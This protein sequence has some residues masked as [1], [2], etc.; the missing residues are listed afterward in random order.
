MP[1]TITDTHAGWTCHTG[2][3]LIAD[4]MTPGPG[5]LGTLHGV[6][7]VCPTHQD[8]AEA[9]ITA[10]GYTPRTEPAP[11]GHRWDPWP[12]GHITAYKQ[13]A[14]PTLAGHLTS[15]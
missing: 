4:A 2:S 11:P 14:A 1:V 6:I 3:S 9:R 8:D 10:A 15:I 7:Y 13:D 5:A 12:C